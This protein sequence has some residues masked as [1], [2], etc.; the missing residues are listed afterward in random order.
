MTKRPAIGV[1]CHGFLKIDRTA[2]ALHGAHDLAVTRT[3]IRFDANRTLE[4]APQTRPFIGDSVATFGWPVTSNEVLETA[5]H[6]P[7]AI[8]GILSAVYPHP[9][10]PLRTHAVYLA[11]L[12][13]QAGDSGGPVISLYSGRVIGVASGRSLRLAK[14][15]VKDPTQDDIPGQVRV[16]LARIAPIT[17]VMSLNPPPPLGEAQ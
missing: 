8:V 3:D 6:T 1:S 5:L 4:L 14:R 2:I 12:P 9:T 7:S 13:T 16:G 17:H 10:L 11:Q 15:R